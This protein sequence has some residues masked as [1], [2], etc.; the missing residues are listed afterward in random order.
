MKKFIAY[1]QNFIFPAD[2]SAIIIRNR[3]HLLVISAL[4]A[5][6]AAV[7]Q[8]A[9]GLIPGIGYF[10]SPFATLPVVVAGALSLTGGLFTFILAIGLLFMLQPG[11]LVIFPFTTGLL[12]LAIGLSIKM[13]KRRLPVVLVSG[14]ALFTGIAFVAFVLRFPLFGPSTEP[15]LAMLLSVLGFSFLYSFIW[16]E[17]SRFFL[18]RLL[19]VLRYQ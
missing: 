4:L 3:T 5:A 10:I 11:E 17:V 16:V 8:S 1:W 6:L 7:L 12:G 19:P 18:R 9:G 2:S 14:F 15:G 13:L